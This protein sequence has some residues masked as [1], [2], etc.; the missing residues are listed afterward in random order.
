MEL[1]LDKMS[2]RNN[3][4]N[5]IIGKSLWCL[6]KIWVPKS[7]INKIEKTVSNNNVPNMEFI[8][9]ATMLWL[10]DKLKKNIWN[11]TDAEKIIDIAKKIT[12]DHV[13]NEV[14]NFFN[15]YS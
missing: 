15:L 1:D 2:K 12:T 8:V 14:N 7:Q 4:S 5:M 10:W 13:N 9:W 3:I 11:E 6:E